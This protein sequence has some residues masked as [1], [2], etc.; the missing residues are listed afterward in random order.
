MYHQQSDSDV[1]IVSDEDLCHATTSFSS[2]PY[3]HLHPVNWSTFGSQ[4][5]WRKSSPV[6]TTL[7]RMFITSDDMI[8]SLCCDVTRNSAVKAWAKGRS[9]VTER[10]SRPHRNSIQRMRNHRASNTIHSGFAMA[11]T[12]T[13][14]SLSRSRQTSS[15]T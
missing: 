10:P 14:S 11:G 4:S 2:G 15:S 7:R 8:A 1:R 6:I 12:I 3:S 13:L 9:R 5:T